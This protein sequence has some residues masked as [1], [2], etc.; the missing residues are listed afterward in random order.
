[1]ANTTT[2]AAE[3][4][5]L[6]GEISFLEPLGSPLPQRPGLTEQLF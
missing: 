4:D 2:P 6:T 3:F 1:M 5:M